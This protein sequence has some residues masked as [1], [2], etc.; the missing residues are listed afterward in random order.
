VVLERGETIG[1]ASIPDHLGGGG[2]STGLSLDMLGEEPLPK[3]L[4]RLTSRHEQSLIKEALE[5]A[6]GNKTQ[7]ARLLGIS[8]VNLHQKINQ[9]GME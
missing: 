5:R 8:R 7:A 9:Y 4:K 1:L 6:G 2:G 3:V